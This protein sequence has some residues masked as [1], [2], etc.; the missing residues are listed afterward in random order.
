MNSGKNMT[1]KIWKEKSPTGDLVVLILFI[2]FF[3]Y[4]TSGKSLLVQ[5]SHLSNGIM[6]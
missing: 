2:Y 1:F 6:L 5:Y 3:N 4:V